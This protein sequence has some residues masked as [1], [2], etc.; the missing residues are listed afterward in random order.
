[1]QPRNQLLAIA[2]LS[3]AAQTDSHATAAED[4]HI[5]QI[6]QGVLKEKDQKIEQ[7]EARIKQLEQERSGAVA[8]APTPAVSSAGAQTPAPLKT[9][10]NSKPEPTFDNK[11]KALDKKINDLKEA[12]EADGL[13]ISGFFDVNAK[14]SNSTDQ[15]FSV[16]SVELD[17]D[18]VHD[19]HFGAS[20][21]LVLCGNSSNTDYAAPVAV[22]CGNSGPGG[23]SGGGTAAGFAV[24]LVDYHLYNDR[25]PPRGRIFNNQGLHIQAGRFDLPF[26]SDY[27]YFANKDRVTITA[28][29]TTSRIQL[30]GFNGDGVRSYGS[31][32]MFNYSAFW[33]DAM[34]ADD[35]HAIGGRLG[36][37]IGQNAYKIH[38][39]NPEGIEFGIS[40]LSE[41]DRNNNIRNT[42]YGADFSIGY[43]MLRLYNE[44]MLLQSHQA[45]F[46]DANGNIVPDF[47][48]ANTPFGK[49]HQLGYHS[50]LTADLEN[51][52]KQPI[53]A[54]VRYS[55]WQ[56][57]QK[58]GLDF[59]GSTVAIND[60]SMLS[61]GFNYKFSDHVRIKF[62][63][64]DA[65][66][67][68][69]AE[70]YFD[71]KMGIAQIVMSF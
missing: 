67:T 66:G 20:T 59:D 3:L 42:V 35:G 24:A 4:E 48:D 62:E 19:D 70:R 63:Y 55:S 33:T 26:G 61:L 10:N 34:Y 39:S 27:Q 23:L 25:I 58:L 2:L 69:I 6:V 44:V 13:Q 53:Q 1:M 18:Y 45:V 8:A 37:A 51:L 21:A 31:F 5:R 9:A 32:G 11:L 52:I 40:H 71:K 60:I 16:G 50:T 17:L 57:S 22:T 43:G 49:G 15:T 14:T 38:N 54:F 56:P 30:G 68:W 7:L 28:P 41:L 46:L 12:A 65:L 47:S 36:M 29:L 64:N